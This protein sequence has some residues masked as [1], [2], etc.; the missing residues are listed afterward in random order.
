M[1]VM[2]WNSTQNTCTENIIL[3]KLTNS[4]GR[5]GLTTSFQVFTMWYG[6][7]CSFLMIITHSCYVLVFYYHQKGHSI[8][9]HTVNTWSSVV[10]PSISPLRGNLLYNIPTPGVKIYL[11]NIHPAIKFVPVGVKILQRE[12]FSPVHL[13]YIINIVKEYWSLLVNCEIFERKL[14]LRDKWKPSCTSRSFIISYQR[15]HTLS[16]LFITHPHSLGRHHTNRSKLVHHHTPYL[17]YITNQLTYNYGNKMNHPHVML[18]LGNQDL[19]LSIFPN[20]TNFLHPQ[21]WLRDSESSQIQALLPSKQSTLAD[22]SLTSVQRQFN[23][24]LTLDWRQ[25]DICRR[26]LFTGWVLHP[27]PWLRDSASSQIQALLG[28]PHRSMFTWQCEQPDPGIVGS[29]T[30]KHGHVTVRAAR[31]RHCWVLHQRACSRDSECCC[32]YSLL[33]SGLW[34]WVHCFVHR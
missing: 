27:Q 15:G 20:L 5:N 22:V 16:H 32:Y 3:Y 33:H 6:I 31:S 30:H 26:R 9:Y 34:C 21:P 8:P 29:S 2:G 24:E 28:P 17:T 19:P 1:L 25:T 11:W 4:R 14:L 23:V 12:I 13:V 7:S 18:G 10:N